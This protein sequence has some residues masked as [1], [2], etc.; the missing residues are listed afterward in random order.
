MLKKTITYVDYDGNERSEEFMFN[1]T[2]AEITQMEFG[3][4]GGLSNLLKKIVA[5]QDLKRIMEYF[6]TLILS[7][8]GEKSLDGKHFHKSEEISKNFEN[9]EAYSVLFMEI[10]RDSKSAADFVNGIVPKDARKALAEA[11]APSLPGPST[12]SVVSHDN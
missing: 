3:T 11:S 9:T 5:E 2:H 7:A 6:R 12:M 1:L 10:V 4:I 8:Y